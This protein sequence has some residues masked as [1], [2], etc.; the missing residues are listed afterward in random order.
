MWRCRNDRSILFRYYISSP[1]TNYGRARESSTTLKTAIPMAVAPSMGVYSCRNL[2]ILFGRLISS[3][4]PRCLPFSHSHGHF[5]I[6][7]QFGSLM[8]MWCAHQRFTLQ[9]AI[10]KLR[11]ASHTQRQLGSF[12]RSVRRS[13]SLGSMAASQFDSFEKI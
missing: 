5:T 10:L 12:W 9:M 7:N 8:F 3:L 6:R 1:C 13:T 4:L 11:N 2:S